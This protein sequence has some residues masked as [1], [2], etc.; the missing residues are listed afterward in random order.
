MLFSISLNLS[1]HIGEKWSTAILF[2]NAGPWWHRWSGSDW[3]PLHYSRTPW[4]TNVST[5]SHHTQYMSHVFKQ[6]TGNSNIIKLNS[7]WNLWLLLEEYKLQRLV[8]ACNVTAV[9]HQ[10][11]MNCI[12][13]SLAWAKL[14]QCSDVPYNL[15]LLTLSNAFWP[16]AP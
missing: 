6:G 1:I 16:T 4:F 15:Q 12:S 11:C 10:I 2:L 14:T 5:E 3:F 13:V 9:Y 7:T 8:Y